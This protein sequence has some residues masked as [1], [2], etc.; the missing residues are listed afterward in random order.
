MGDYTDALAKDLKRIE[1]EVA[2]LDAALKK[3]PKDAAALKS[4]QQVT[5]FLAPA[6]LKKRY[7]NALKM[8]ADAMRKNFKSMGF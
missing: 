7:D 4:K 5:A 3:N 2:K 6:S 8:D 1:G